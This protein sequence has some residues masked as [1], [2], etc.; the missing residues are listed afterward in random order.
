MQHMKPAWLIALL[1]PTILATHLT[2]SAE[3][4]HRFTWEH[5]FK[6]PGIDDDASGITWSPV[7]DHLYVIIDGPE[8]VI[9]LSKEGKALR[10]IKLKG[11]KG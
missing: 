11:L 4:L 3:T 9:E 10:Q 5:A 7:T 1:L 6:I 8:R 2:A